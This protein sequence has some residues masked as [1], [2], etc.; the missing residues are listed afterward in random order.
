MPARRRF[1]IRF[2]QPRFVQFRLAYVRFRHKRFR[3][4]RLTRNW[5]ARHRLTRNWFTRNWLARLR[6]AQ[7]RCPQV[8]STRI[9]APAPDRSRWRRGRESELLEADLDRPSHLAFP[10]PLRLARPLTCGRP[11]ILTREATW[12]Q[13]RHVVGVLLCERLPQSLQFKNQ[14]RALWADSIAVRLASPALLGFGVIL[15]AIGS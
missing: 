5:L 4:D 11:Q 14:R 7:V 1:D 2:A 3:P 10:R 6:W 15:G 13:W 8:R 12:L 9:F